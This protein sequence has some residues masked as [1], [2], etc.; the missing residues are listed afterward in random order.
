MIR[1][2]KRLGE[3]EGK[4]GIEDISVGRQIRLGIS[5]LSLW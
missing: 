4:G 1:R 2:E 3:G 5:K